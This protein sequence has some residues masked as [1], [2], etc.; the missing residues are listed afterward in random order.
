MIGEVEFRE[1]QEELSELRDSLDL[2]AAKAEAQEEILLAALQA[3][4]MQ[5]DLFADI[6]DRT[7]GDWLLKRR[8]LD[9]AASKLL[10]RARDDVLAKLLDLSQ[11]FETANRRPT[12]RVV[13]ALLP[14]AAVQGGE[15]ST[16]SVEHSP[17][18]VDVPL[19]EQFSIPHGQDAELRS[20]DD[21]Q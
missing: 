7:L 10:L 5:A 14:S 3:L 2:M 1:M 4:P 6:I 20:E 16:S 13:P 19:G 15:V 12:L 21:D 18:P 17:R 11:G 8:S 9:S